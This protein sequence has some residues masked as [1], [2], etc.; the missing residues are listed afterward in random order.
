MPDRLIA[1][2]VLVRDLPDRSIVATLRIERIGGNASAHFSATC[3]LHEA[4]VTGSGAG[5]RRRGSEP[6]LS[7]AA[8]GEILAAFPGAAAFVQMHLAEYPSGVPMHA[9]A[10]GFYFLTGE[11]ER[12]EREHYGPAYTMR[13][14]SRLTRCARALRLHSADDIPYELANAAAAGALT[15]DDRPAFA[16]FVDTLRPRWESEARAAIAILEMMPDATDLRGYSTSGE[17]IKRRPLP[18]WLIGADPETVDV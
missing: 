4:H 11:A 8:H 10:N 1:Q 7:G 13:A 5:E 16:A 6:E 12:Y 15:D 17:Q 9:E 14:G 2:R 3:E 18:E